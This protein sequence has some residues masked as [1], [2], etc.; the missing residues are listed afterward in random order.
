MALQ[1]AHADLIAFAAYHCGKDLDHQSFLGK[2]VTGDH[3]IESQPVRHTEYQHRR[4]E[5][6]V[7]KWTRREQRSVPEPRFKPTVDNASLSGS[8]PFQTILGAISA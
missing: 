4:P 3:Q 5:G 1:N 2:R 7:N 8:K 6:S